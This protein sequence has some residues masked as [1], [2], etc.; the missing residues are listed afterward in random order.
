MSDVVATPPGASIPPTKSFPERLLGVFVSPDV[1]FVDIV[2]KPDFIAPLIVG[3]VAAVAVTETMLAKIGMER[4]VRMS[5]EQSGQASRMT[6]EQ[7]QRAVEQGARFGTIFAHLGGLVGVPIFLL[8]TATLGLLI[9]NV[10]LG[11]QAKFT[12]V[13]SV[14]C[15]ANL[16]GIL[17]ALMAIPII[18]F[19]D[20]ERFN[21]QNATPSNVAFFLNPLDTSKALYSLASSADIIWVWTMILLAMGWSQASGGKGK[22]LPIFLAYFGLWVIWVLGKIGFAMLTA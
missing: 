13:F 6:P 19:G 20:P 12:T 18:L 9:L 14:T 8:I 15:Y 3:I 7:I 2:R 5:I 21:A 1:A 11:A 22:P 4:I 16:V 10:I 17:G